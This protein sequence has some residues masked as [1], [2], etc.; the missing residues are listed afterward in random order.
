MVCVCVNVSVI[1]ILADRFECVLPRLGQLAEF[2]IALDLV[3]FLIS[4]TTSVYYYCTK[5]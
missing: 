4:C 1:A 5:V 2:F 3:V